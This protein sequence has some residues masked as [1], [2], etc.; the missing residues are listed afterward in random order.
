MLSRFLFSALLM[1]LGAVLGCAEPPSPSSTAA[2]ADAGM[3]AN[4]DAALAGDASTEASSDGEIQP[5]ADAVPGG[6]ALSDVLGDVPADAAAD[7]LAPG[8]TD[9]SPSVDSPSGDSPGGDSPSADAGPVDAKDAAP[10]AEVTVGP[11]ES[12]GTFVVG[13]KGPCVDPADLAPPA[14]LL[15]SCSAGKT[16]VGKGEC[17]PATAFWADATAAPDQA[18][19][20]VATRPDGG[21]A[22]AWSVGDFFMGKQQIWTRVFALGTELGS[23][24]VQVSSASAGLPNLAPSVAAMGDGTWM[25]MWRQ[26]D[27]AKDE[28]RYLAQKVAADGQSLIGQPQ[29]VNTTLLGDGASSGS[30]NIIAPVVVRLRNGRLLMAW[31]GGAKNAATKLGIYARLFDE[32]G[33]PMTGELDTG[34]VLTSSAAYSPAIA[35]LPGGAVLLAW[36]GMLAGGKGQRVVRGRE[37]GDTG[38]PL[39]PVLTLSPMALPYE[40]LPAVAGYASG[41]ALALWKAGNNASATSAV[42]VLGGLIGSASP[43]LLAD[44]PEGTY[45]GAAPVAVLSEHR[46]MAVWHNMGG[47]SHNIWARRHYRSVDAWDCQL[48]ELGGP[49]LPGEADSRYLPALA[50]WENGKY[51]LVFSASLQGMDETRVGVRLGHW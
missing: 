16:C 21:F 48:T 20:A 5:G 14:C 42:G 32:S 50:T 3:A 24:A 34:A 27:P 7:V 10:I 26:V 36:E 25:V 41:H 47:P 1:T 35:A 22:V 11:G 43:T 9:G 40:A 31:S 30:T 33:K 2:A 38:K 39:G 17:V 49:F 46:A 28:V 12:G 51:A 44:D 8:G 15:V 18:W 23:P 29:Q 6:D 45:P 37:F 4:S 13:P 19:G